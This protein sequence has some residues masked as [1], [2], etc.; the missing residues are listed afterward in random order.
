[1]F[2]RSSGSNLR[3]DL[4]RPLGPKLAIYA[5]DAGPTAAGNPLAAMVTPY[6]GLTLSLQ[7]RDHAA[8]GQAIWKG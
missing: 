6:T 8:I 2:R 5:Q 3:E 7:V 4:L 1:M